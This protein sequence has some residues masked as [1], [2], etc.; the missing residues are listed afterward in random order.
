[1]LVGPVSV[2]WCQGPVTQIPGGV[3][4]P[5]AGVGVGVRR[6]TLPVLDLLPAKEKTDRLPI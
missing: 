1:M 2:R 5:A 4:L 6:R 3:Q